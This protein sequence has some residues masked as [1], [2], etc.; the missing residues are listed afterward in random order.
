MA[1]FSQPT[2]RALA[3]LDQQAAL[4][5]NTVPR[6]AQTWEVPLH[7]PDILASAHLVSA[8]TLGYELSGDPALLDRAK[9]W[10]W[11]GVPPP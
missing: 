2:A 1:L 10:A 8:Y 4:Y 9:Y 6:G 7:T 11:T 3:I 5:A